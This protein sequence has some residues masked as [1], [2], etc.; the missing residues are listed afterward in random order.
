MIFKK[1]NKNFYDHRV[2]LDRVTAFV[3]LVRNKEKEITVSGW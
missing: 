1:R 3:F 2:V